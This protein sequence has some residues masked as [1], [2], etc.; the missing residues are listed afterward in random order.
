MGKYF[1]CLAGALLLAGC[2]EDTPTCAK[3]SEEAD[4]TSQYIE[5]HVAEDV[6]K[7]K[8][9]GP[10]ENR[11]KYVDDIKEKAQFG[12]T[13]FSQLKQKLGGCD[14]SKEEKAAINSKLDDYRARS[15]VILM[16]AN[17]L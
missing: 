8:Y 15:G 13:E 10:A 12:V 5:R 2:S 11:A 9:A 17:N 4:S 3:V 14:C 6:N 1:L 16:E 7:I